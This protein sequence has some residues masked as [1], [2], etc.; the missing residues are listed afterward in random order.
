MNPYF[1]FVDDVA[2]AKARARS[3]PLGGGVPLPRPVAAP[4]APVL[5]MSPHP[6][7]ECIVGGL[8]LRLMR[9]A[10]QHI[11]NIAITLGSNKARRQGRW[12]ELSAACQFLGFDFEATTPSGLERITPKV[13]L[14]DHA[15]WSAAVQTVA[16]TIQKHQPRALFLPH[17]FDWN[18]THIGTHFLVTDA[19]KTLPSSFETILVETEFWGA[20]YNPNLMVELA[21]A[22]LADLLAALSFH[23]GEVQRNPYHLSLPAWMQDNVRR[24][25]EVVGGQ[26][27]AAPEMEFATLYRVRRW[28][29]GSVQDLPAGGKVVG[30]RDFPGSVIGITPRSA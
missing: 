11:I 17:E 15:H 20:I 14:E 16:A 8:A 12:D 21:A 25:A 28:R 2:K 5:V 29:G 13:R 4:G 22:D 6:D 1:Q 26:G 7:D 27:A 18:G 19:L 9:E 30:A 3:L 23:V 24:G 10:G